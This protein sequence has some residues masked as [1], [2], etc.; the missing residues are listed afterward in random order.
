[1]NI[2]M[3]MIFDGNE[4]V[5]AIWHVTFCY[6]IPCIS[7]EYFMDKFMPWLLKMANLCQ[8]LISRRA[9]SVIIRTA[10]RI[11]AKNSKLSGSLLTVYL[12]LCQDP[13]ITIRK[14][15]LTNLCTL[16]QDID[17]ISADNDFFPEVFFLYSISQTTKK[18]NSMYERFKLC[19][20]STRYDCDYRKPS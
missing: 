15:T 1:M 18:D 12:E 11:A 16:L 3:N 17:E 13:D 20:Q 7:W 4:D 14:D 9:A 6:G 10:S 8:T 2:I 5:V 19:I